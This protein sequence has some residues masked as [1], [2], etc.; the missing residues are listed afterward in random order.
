V[1]DTL[2]RSPL[3]CLETETD[4]H[5]DVACYIAAIVDAL[6][7]TPRRL[8]AIKTATAADC[9]L[10]L[11]LQY[12]KSGWPEYISQVPAAIREYFPMKAELSECNGIVIRGSRM[13]IPDVLRTDI[14]NRIQ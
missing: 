10:Q 14:L 11:V 1:A 2:S 6:P 3:Q 13:V 9:N 7:A 12:I 8:K 4:I 5:S